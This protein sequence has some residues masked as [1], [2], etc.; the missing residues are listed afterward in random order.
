MKALLADHAATIVK[1]HA[2]PGSTA[3]HRVDLQSYCRSN[4]VAI[5]ANIRASRV[6][7]GKFDLAPFMNGMGTT[8]VLDIPNADPIVERTD[9]EVEDTINARFAALDLMSL[10]VVSRQFRSI[11]VSGNPGIGKTYTLEYILESAAADEKIIFAPIRGYVRASGLYKLLYENRFKNCVIMFDDAD[12]VFAD[13][14]AL[15]L[16]KAALDTTK[17]RTLNWRSEMKFELSDGE[18]VP[19]SFDFEGAV[20]FVTNLDF[21]RQIGSNSRLAPH[22]EALMSRSYY[23]DLNL[24]TQQELLVRIQSVVKK[25]DIL[26]SM[27]VSRADQ[28]TILKYIIDNANRMRELSLRTIIKLGNIMKAAKDATEFVQMAD[29]TCTVRGR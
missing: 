20:V 23:L 9:D 22:L 5:P 12:S 15:N 21:Q 6:G 7:G 10:G 25:S 24:T 4:N 26:N 1:L 11:I 16:L 14:T 28:K 18:A 13:E 19:N 2:K 29:A 3:V 27:N 17:K 8:R